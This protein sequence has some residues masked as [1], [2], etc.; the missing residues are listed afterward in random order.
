MNLVINKTPLMRYQRGFVLKMHLT[1]LFG[2][3]CPRRPN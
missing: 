3:N 2:Y 1:L